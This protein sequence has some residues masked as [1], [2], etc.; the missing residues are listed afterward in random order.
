MHLHLVSVVCVPD[1]IRSYIM[2]PTKFCGRH[3]I[4]LTIMIGGG[5]EFYIVNLASIPSFIYPRY[6]QY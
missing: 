5:R 3:N 2:D 6:Q 4:L 1:D